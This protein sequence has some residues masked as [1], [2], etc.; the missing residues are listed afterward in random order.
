MDSYADTI[1]IWCVCLWPVNISFQH[2]RIRLFDIFGC[3]YYFYLKPINFKCV[4]FNLRN[5]I[6]SAT[7]FLA[8]IEISHWKMNR[9]LLFFIFFCCWWELF[10]FQNHL[11][12]TNLLSI[13]FWIRFSYCFMAVLIFS[14]L[15]D[16][17]L[18]V[19]LEKVAFS[20]S[21]QFEVQTY[22]NLA[23]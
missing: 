1:T 10:G 19:I 21:L 7:M 15:E 12:R 17:N 20:S 2:L 13:F 22:S 3:N 9:D 18:W 23:Y 8:C 5:E 16:V 11:G 14:L 6:N 4:L